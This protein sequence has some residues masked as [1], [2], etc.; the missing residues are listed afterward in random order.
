MN[1]GE[2]HHRITRNKKGRDFVIGDIH[3]AMNKLKVALRSVN[4]DESKDRLFS[5]GDLIDRGKSNL[6]IVTILFESDWFF[7]IRGNHEQ[8]LID[9]YEFPMIKPAYMSGVKTRYEAAELHQYNGGKWFD[10]LRSDLAKERIYHILAKLPYA[11]TLE[12]EFGDI[13]LVHAE[14]PEEFADWE[15]FIFEMVE[16]SKVREKCIWNRMAIQDVYNIYSKS[17]VIDEKE[18]IS[19]KVEGVLATVHG[20]TPVPRVVVNQ[21]QYWIDTGYK[22]GNLTIIDVTDLG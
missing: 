21:N 6:A 14:V 16:N 7:A 12:T 19:R 5:V 17:G 8:M 13:G 4:F 11:I 9:R 2:F 1:S 15:E 20:H 10:R 3:G 18:I 22:T